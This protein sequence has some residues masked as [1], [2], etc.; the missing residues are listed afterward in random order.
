MDFRVN[1]FMSHIMNLKYV[2][3]LLKQKE[4][5]NAKHLLNM[6]SLV[7]LEVISKLLFEI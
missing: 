5:T 4:N 3:N 7:T 2:F 6:E 1:L